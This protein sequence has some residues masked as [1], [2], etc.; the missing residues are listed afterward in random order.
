MSA[1]PAP[2]SVAVPTPGNA[3]GSD[4]TAPPRAESLLRRKTMPRAMS[5]GVAFGMPQAIGF[6]SGLD[7]VAS[8]AHDLVDRCFGRSGQ[9][10]RQL[11]DD[12]QRDGEGDHAHNALPS[13]VAVDDASA[14]EV[15]R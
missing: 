11:F 7:G 4:E 6:D 12:L 9:A 5:L 3:P 10:H 13:A 2:I 15:V 14:R 8:Q 1:R